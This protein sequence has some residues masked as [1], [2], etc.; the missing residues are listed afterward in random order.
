[1]FKVTKS[2]NPALAGSR[3]SSTSSTTGV[4]KQETSSLGVSSNVMAS[5]KRDGGTRMESVSYNNSGRSNTM[6]GNN[7][8]SIDT[9][10]LLT[11]LVDEHSHLDILSKIYRDMYYNDAICGCAVDLMANLPFSSFN[12]GGLST[13]GTKYEKA[14]GVFHEHMERLNIRTLLPEIS[15]DYLTLG[16][17]C[18]SLLYNRQLKKFTDLMPHTIETLDITPLPFYSQDPII[19]VTFPP[20]VTA[21]LSNT[22][23]KRIQRIRENLGETVVQKLTGGQLELDPLSTVYIP[24]RTFSSNDKGTSYLR[25]VLPIYLIEKNL[26]RGTLVESARRQ[27]GILHITA[28]DGDAWLP[29]VQ[30]L[31]FITNIF[32]DADSDPL[33]SIIATRMGIATEEL[34]QGGDFWKV[35]DYQD[36]VAT[37]KMRA[38]CISESL[39]S[40]EASYATTD[41]NLTVFIDS[42]RTFR[43]MLTQKFLYNKIFPLIS[44]TNGFAV[45]NGKLD[46]RDDL[47]RGKDSEEV[48][49]ELN[50]GSKLFIPTV[51][52]TKALKPEGDTTYLDMLDR[53]TTLGVPVPLRVLAA[54]GGFNLEDLL[55]QQEED[56][57]TRK[58]TAD[59]MKAL[60]KLKPADAGAES[61]SLSAGEEEAVTD[62]LI[63]L[64]SVDPS[65]NTRS[66]LHARGGRVSL[67]TRQFDSPHTLGKTGKKKHVFNTSSYNARHNNNIVKAVKEVDK[68]QRDLDKHSR[69]R[70]SLK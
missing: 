5:N 7:A 23:S 16:M 63:G 42:L 2:P 51:H 46:I 59:Y 67:L 54:A 58:R 1:M 18:S 56:L 43:D 45:R 65:G 26:F 40:G 9:D 34:R 70:S 36:S 31:E 49:A 53:M 17:H 68:K 38:L 44:L 61:S 12:L 10:P 8:I 37:H 47:M 32:Q 62:A 48:L 14:I 52:Y 33:G 27:R 41:A 28:G 21:I 24:R 20:E 22:S 4:V 30:D 55:K 15:V 57:A 6:I 25:R 66:A 60:S 11:N 35:G 19:K 64:A 50:D 13:G 39:L 69:R 3:V 29:T